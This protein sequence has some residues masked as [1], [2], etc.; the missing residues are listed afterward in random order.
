MCDEKVTIFF[1]LIQ[2]EWEVGIIE[3]QQKL[4][5]GYKKIS[6]QKCR[7]SLETQYIVSFQYFG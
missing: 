1:R 7:L 3:W 6:T 5:R 2:R 4:N